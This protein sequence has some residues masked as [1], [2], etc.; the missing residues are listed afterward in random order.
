MDAT[1]WLVKEPS[2]CRRIHKVGDITQT[3]NLSLRLRCRIIDYEAVVKVV[4]DLLTE[5]RAVH[6]VLSDFLESTWQ[7]IHKLMPGVDTRRRLFP[8]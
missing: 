6:R 4:T 5:A 3:G 1:V 8:M 2:L 7:A